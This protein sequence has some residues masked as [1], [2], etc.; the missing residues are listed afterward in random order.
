[1][2]LC[3]GVPDAGGVSVGAAD[4][5]MNAVKLC[6]ELGDAWDDGVSDCVELLDTDGE[7]VVVLSAV[8]LSAGVPDAGGVP[9]VAADGVMSAVKLSK[10]LRDAWDDGVSDCVELLDTDGDPVKLCNGEYVITPVE[11]PVEESEATGLCELL[12]EAVAP[13]LN[14]FAEADVSVVGLC[15]T[16]PLRVP[17]RVEEAQ[18][19]KEPV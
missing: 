13:V 14:V 10:E 15:E 18:P 12:G 4:D 19:D 6:G 11:L 9:V 5:V 8:I 2:K 1:V 3:A 17:V 16:V 7:P